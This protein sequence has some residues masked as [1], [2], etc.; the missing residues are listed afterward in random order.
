M[1]NCALLIGLAMNANT[2]ADPEIV[3]MD[4]PWGS[5]RAECEQGVIRGYVEHN[6]S[7]RYH[8][9]GYGINKF[10]VELKVLEW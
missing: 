7:I 5:V 4:N 1:M 9:D 3:N 8:E 6:T 10:G 2:Y